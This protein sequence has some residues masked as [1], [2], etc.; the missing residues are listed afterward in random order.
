[1]ILISWLFLL[2]Y[3]FFGVIIAEMILDW[4]ANDK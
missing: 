2:T 1:M 4:F 3:L